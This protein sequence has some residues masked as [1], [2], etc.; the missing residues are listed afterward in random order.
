VLSRLT[1]PIGALTLALLAVGCGPSEE[2]IP[3]NALRVGALLPFTGK[4]AAIGRNLEQALLLAVN[5]V[6]E[7]GG[8]EGRPLVLV[9]R[10]SNSGSARGF[11]Q[12][13]QL[14]YTDGVD[15][16]IG[17]EETEL[18]SAIVPDVKGLNVLN[19]LPGYTAPSIEQTGSQG[20]WIRLAPSTGALGCGMAAHVVRDGVKTVNAL[21]TVDDFNTSL[22]TDFTS[23]FG[24]LKGE[25]LPSVTAPLGASSYLRQINQVLD[26]EAERTLLMAPPAS[27]STIA[28][29][30]TIAGRRGRWYLSPLLR[31]EVFLQNIPFGTLNGTQGLSPSLSLENECAEG[32]DGALTCTPA[33]SV[34]FANHFA[35]HWRGDRPFPAANFY[36]DAVVL[37]ALALEQSVVEDGELPSTRKL[38]DRIRALGDPDLQPVRWGDLRGPMT[39]IRLG[40]P[41]RYVGAGAEYEF[42]TYGAAQHVV[43]DTWMIEADRFV[44]TG[45]LRA[46]CKHTL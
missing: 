31:A 7:A 43:F 3:E 22:A 32:A 29:E 9:T 24:T 39:E 6:N 35:E 18:A 23:Q 1:G 20:G 26:Y 21:T 41:V 46:E 2:S 17:P 34:A 5:D 42:D 25:S 44:D 14:L 33:N 28:T 40:T 11:E 19:I 10:D 37:L 13:L 36:Y 12:L 8:I 30:W 16:L 45:T 15:Y 27:A 4:E 38:R